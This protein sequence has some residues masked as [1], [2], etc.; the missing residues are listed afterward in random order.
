MVW[1]DRV[2]Y[3]WEKTTH[4]GSDVLLTMLVP[5]VETDRFMLMVL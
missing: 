1:Q 5:Y 4:E 3:S 2:D